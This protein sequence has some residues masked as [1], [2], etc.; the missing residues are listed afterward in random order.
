[1][2]FEICFNL[3]NNN[4]LHETTKQNIAK[5]FLI[6]NYLD[7]VPLEMI[8]RSDK[9]VVKIPTTYLHDCM[10]KFQ[11]IFEDGMSQ[12]ISS[13]DYFIDY[14]CQ[15]LNNYI[16]VPERINKLTSWTFKGKQAY[17]DFMLL[18]TNVN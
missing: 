11:I 6:T 3:S 5:I 1:M 16:T 10:F 18:N 2:C 17:D 7:W 13:N 8:K 4:V 9:F 12:Y 15:F 14:H